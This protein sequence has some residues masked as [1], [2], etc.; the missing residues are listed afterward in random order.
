MG[1]VRISLLMKGFASTQKGTKLLVLPYVGVVVN[2][3]STTSRI[4]ETD[5]FCR[6]SVS[7]R[8]P[9]ERSAV[10]ARVQ[11]ALCPMFCTDATDA[12]SFKRVVQAV[13]QYGGTCNVRAR[14]VRQVA[15]H[16]ICW[17]PR[18]SRHTQLG[19]L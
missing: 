6:L 16:Q 15:L 13:H 4:D 2:G 12:V 18:I 5:P 8:A 14:W 3:C 10:F 19:C 11:S 1:G 17:C 9:R 7:K